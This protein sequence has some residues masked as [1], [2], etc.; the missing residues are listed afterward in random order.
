MADVVTILLLHLNRAPA[1]HDNFRNTAKYH[2]FHNNEMSRHSAMWWYFF[3]VIP[4][5]SE[6][7]QAAEKWTRILC[8]PGMSRR[9]LI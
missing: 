1:N 6:A 3:N 8:D 5:R 4:I 9:T 7:L 2:A